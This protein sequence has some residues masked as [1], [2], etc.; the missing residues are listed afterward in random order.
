[1]HTMNSY[2]LNKKPE[3]VSLYQIILQTFKALSSEMIR[4]LCLVYV[5]LLEIFTHIEPIFRAFFVGLPMLLCYECC[6][7][8]S[9]EPAMPRCCLSGGK[10][11]F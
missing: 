7:Y 2:V 1:M 5:K 10:S 6:S 8:P 9:V 11:L 4:G 3:L